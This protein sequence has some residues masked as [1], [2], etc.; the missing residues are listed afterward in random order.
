MTMFIL[1]VGKPLNSNQSNTDLVWIF[2]QF[3]NIQVILP[4][5]PFQRHS[6]VVCLDSGIDYRL[7][8][9]PKEG[10]IYFL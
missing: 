10:S 2:I 6:E 1:E 4:F 8:S 9:L 7:T 5:Q 3:T